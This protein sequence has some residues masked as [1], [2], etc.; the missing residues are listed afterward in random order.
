MSHY[1]RGFFRGLGMGSS[2]G[3]IVGGVFMFCVEN[4]VAMVLMVFTA[5][6]G[7]LIWHRFGGNHESS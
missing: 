6:V 7:A 3:G 2:I 1:R 4:Y 5:L